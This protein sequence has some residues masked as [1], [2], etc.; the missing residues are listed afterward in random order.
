MKPIACVIGAAL[1]QA[2]GSHFC[3]A[4]SLNGEGADFAGLPSLF[5]RGGSSHEVRGATNA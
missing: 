4:L 2:L 5:R 1:P 3:R